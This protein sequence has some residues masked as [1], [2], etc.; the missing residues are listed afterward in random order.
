MATFSQIYDLSLN[1]T[2]LTFGLY[3]NIQYYNGY[4]YGGYGGGGAGTNFLY[5]LRISDSSYNTVIDNSFNGLNAITIDTVNNLIYC[6]S[7]E[8]TSII[9]VYN[10]DLTLQSTL[11]LSKPINNGKYI[12]V[13]GNNLFIACD[14]NT[15]GLIESINRTTGLVSL[16]TYSTTLSRIQAMA[17]HTT[18]II[19]V[20]LNNQLYSIIQTGAISP[21]TPITTITPPPSTITNQIAIYNGDVYIQYKDSSSYYIAQYDIGGA[22]FYSISV[23]QFFDNSNLAGITFNTTNGNMYVRQQNS[24]ILYRSSDYC[25]NEGSQILYLNKKMKDQYIP[26]EHLK[27]G[28]FVKTFKHGY[29]K[30]SKI[31]KGS[32]KNN[33]KNWNMCMY[34]MIKTESNGL[35]EDL[36]VT[37][38]HSLL[39]DSISEV[40]QAKYDKMGLTDWSKQTIDGKRLLLASVSDQFAPMPDNNRYT[41]YHLLLENNNDEEERFGI[42]S[43]GILTETPNEKTLK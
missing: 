21:S 41:Y 11:T 15:A 17:I 26:V 12:C 33:P 23:P 34:K 31:I 27:K 35:L 19:Y 1:H 29:R 14:N 38:G 5:R 37:G 6:Y 28:D 9:V 25:F 10:L 42:W 39:V 16:Q 2:G 7:P 40:E 20:M 36:I 24:S 8:Q 3:P 18:G 30:V 32:F 4:I 13:L 43:N 22:P